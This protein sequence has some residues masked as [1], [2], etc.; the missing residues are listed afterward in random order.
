MQEKTKGV[1]H[2][3]HKEAEI[4]PYI[5]GE[6]REHILTELQTLGHA[7]LWEVN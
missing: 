6:H 1:K 2:I 5:Q 7:T 4:P 3:L